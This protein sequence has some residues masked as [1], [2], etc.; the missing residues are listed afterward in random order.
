MTNFRFF[1]A[2]FLLICLSLGNFSTSVAQRNNI[3][4]D[5]DMGNDVDDV[6]A[7]DLLLKY[8]E[9]GKINL[10]AI[11]GNRQAESCCAFIDMYNTWFGFPNIPI[12]QVINGS[13]PTPEEKSYATKTLNMKVNGRP[14]FRMT[15]KDQKAYPNAVDLYRKILSKARNKSIVIVSVGFSSNLSRLMETTGDEY[16]PLSGMELLKKKVSYISVMA[17]NFL[18]NAKPEY[19]VRNDVHAARKLFTKSPVP[20]AF[21]TFDLGKKILYPAA[22]VQ[23]DFNWTNNHPFVKAYESYMKMPYDRPTWDPISALYALEPNMGFFSLS[24]K[25][26]VTVDDKGGTTFTPNENG[27]CRYLITTPE[28]NEKIKKYLVKCISRKPKHFTK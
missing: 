24:E 6:M 8:H 1:G 18:P 3:I 4:F 13:N 26:S 5:T 2:I 17:A 25:G 12:G 11:M 15:N 19:N 16:S 28:Q 9:A 14:M 22:S 20:L 27:N 21:G 10:L 23:N 7:L